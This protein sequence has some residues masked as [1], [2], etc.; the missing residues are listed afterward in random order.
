MGQ[1]PPIPSWSLQAEDIVWRG[2]WGDRLALCCK[3][4]PGESSSCDHAKTICV[5][6]SLAQVKLCNPCGTSCAQLLSSAFHMGERGTEL[7]LWYLPLLAGCWPCTG[8]WCL[9]WQWHWE[10]SYGYFSCVSPVC[11]LRCSDCP[12]LSLILEG[13]TRKGEDHL[14]CC[15]EKKPD[16]NEHHSGP[17]DFLSLETISQ[18]PPVNLEGWKKGK[19]VPTWWSQSGS[20]ARLWLAHLR[21]VPPTRLCSWALPCCPAPGTAAQL[22]QIHF[23]RGCEE[24]ARPGPGAVGEGDAALAAGECEPAVAFSIFACGIW[25]LEAAITFQ[26]WLLLKCL[27]A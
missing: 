3:R 18:V 19:E 12:R 4:P 16:P 15:W 11:G 23:V 13:F 14:L 7:P 22:Q 6:S 2:I 20:V 5:L 26:G 9:G 1:P 8:W 21:A 25:E 24:L 10:A 27:F 17:S